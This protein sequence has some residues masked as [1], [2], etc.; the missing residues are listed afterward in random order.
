MPAVKLFLK[1]FFTDVDQRLSVIFLF[2]EIYPFSFLHSVPIM[3]E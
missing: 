3:I 2:C 1:Y